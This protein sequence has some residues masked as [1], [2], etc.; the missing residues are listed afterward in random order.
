MPFLI[1]LCQPEDNHRTTPI[2]R[3]AEKCKRRSE[4]YFFIGSQLIKVRR[5]VSGICVLES[6]LHD[7]PEPT[8]Y[9]SS[10]CSL[11]CVP[12]QSS[13]LIHKHVTRA[14]ALKALQLMFPL[15]GLLLLEVT[16]RF[17]PLTHSGPHPNVTYLAMPSLC[18]LIK[19]AATCPSSILPLCA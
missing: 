1:V 12:S 8:C 11:C 17:P 9:H 4:V 14:S 6:V 13:L 18:T 3:K 15:P 2:S 19:I 7:S 5:L 10:P 16:T